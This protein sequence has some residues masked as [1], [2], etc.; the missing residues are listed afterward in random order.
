RFNN[1]VLGRTGKRAIE[2]PQ[3]CTKGK[4]VS[5]RVIHGKDFVAVTNSF[6]YQIAAPGKKT[7][8]EWSQVL[9]FPA[10]Q[11]YFIS[12]DKITS[13]NASDAMFLRLDMPGHIKHKQGDTFSEAYL[14]YAA[15]IPSSELLKAF[16]PDEKFNY[17]RDA[18]PASKRTFP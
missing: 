15:K 12:S 5:P 17:R 7:G 3:I 6:K 2:G 10:G 8:S 13:V 16:A 18:T 9:V 4:G 14:S 1:S 11:R